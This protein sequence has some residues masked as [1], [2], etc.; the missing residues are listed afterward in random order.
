MILHPESG[1]SLLSC[2]DP[3]EASPSD[4]MW[5]IGFAAVDAVEEKAM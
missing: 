5:D 3:V 1:Y 4:R 2:R